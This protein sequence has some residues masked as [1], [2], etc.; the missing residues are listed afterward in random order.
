[1]AH[2]GVLGVTE[3]GLDFQILLDP[4]E[5]ALDLPALLAEVGDGLGCQPEVLGEEPV[6][7]AGFGVLVNEAAQGLGALSG[8]GAGKA[9]GLI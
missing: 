2:H 6:N 8:F 4:A 1:L 5:E 3:E 9:D 7:F